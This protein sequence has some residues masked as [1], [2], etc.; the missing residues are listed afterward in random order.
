M[1]R[2]VLLLEVLTVMLFSCNKQET[3]VP[4]GTPTE[5]SYTVTLEGWQFSKG[6]QL[7]LLSGQHTAALTAKSS[8]ASVVFSG[9]A[10]K[11]SGEDS[12]LAIY[13]SAPEGY[14]LENNVFTFSLP[15]VAVP[16]NGHPC[17]AVATGRPK[18]NALQ[19]NHLTAFLSFTTTRTD[20]T[21]LVIRSNGKSL[22]GTIK[23]TLDKNAAPS[24]RTDITDGTDALVVNDVLTP[25]TYTLPIPAQGYDK[26]S[27][28][29]FTATGSGESS[30]RKS[31]NP[32]FG[33]T[34][35]LGVIDQ[36][37][38]IAERADA[39]AAELLEATSSTAAVTWSVSGFNDVFT[40]IAQKWSAGIYKD[41][42]CTDL[43]VSW[44]FPVGTWSVSDGNNIYALEGPYS[45]RFIF[46][47]LEG[48]STYYVKVWY[49]DN[50]DLASAP[51]KVVTL[52]QENKT[53]P[54]GFAGEGDVLLQEDFSELVWGGDVSTRSYGYSDANRGNAPA[55]HAAAGENPVGKQTI[56]GFEHDWYLAWPG[57]EMGL[58][59][60][61]GK[62]I[63]S[64]RLKDWTSMAEDNTDG[65]ALARPGYVKLGASSQT[66]ALV[67]PALTCLEHRAVVRLS[68]RMHPYR[69]AVN[70]PLTA[71]VMV[72]STEESGIS[73][74]KDYVVTKR[75]DFLVGE[76]QQWYSYSFDLMMQPGE[77]LAIASRREGTDANQRRLLVD[78]IKVELLEYR[79]YVKVTAIK[80]TQDWLDF[81]SG[82]TSYEAGET[83]T[84][85]NDLDMEGLSFDA[86]PSFVGTLDGKGHALL[87][88][89]S[90]GKPLFTALG[91]NEGEGGTVKD[92][93]LDASCSLT[94][95]L[96]G[97]FGFIAAT[98]LPSGVIDGVQIKADAVPLNVPTLAAPHIGMIAGVSYGLIQNCVNDGDLSVTSAAGTGNAY[99]GG[100][101]GYI[102]AGDR[103]GLLNNENN[104]DITYTMNGPGLFA[105]LGGISAGTSTT[106]IADAK[107]SKGTIQNCVN[108][109]KVSYTTT[110]GGSMAENEGTGR[111]GNYFKVGGVIGYFEGNVID[112]TNR[113]EVSARVPTNE[114]AACTTGASIGGVAAFVLRNMTGCKNYGKVNVSGTFAGGNVDNQGCGITAEF[115]AGGVVGQ[116]GAKESPEAYGLSDCHNYGELDLRGWMAYGNGTGFNFGGVVGY[117]G[118]PVSN[119]S[120]EADMLAESK[121]AFVRMGGVA[122]RIVGQKATALENKGALDFRFVRSTA[123]AVDTY[124]QLA[125]ELRAGGVAAYVGG[126]IEDCSNSGELKITTTAEDNLSAALQAGGVVGYTDKLTSLSGSNTGKIDITYNGK[127]LR[128]GGIVGETVKSTALSGLVNSGALN[129]NVPSAGQSW[130]GG[131]LGFMPAGSATLSGLENNGKVDVSIAEASSSAFYY[132]AGV[133]ASSG[134]GYKYSGCVN[135]ADITYSGKAKIRIGGVCAYTNQNDVDSSSS[136]N[137]KATCTGYDYSEV[138]GVCAYT[139]ATGLSGWQFTGTIDTSEST[140]K[141]YT[142]GLLGKSNGKAAFNGC[143]FSGTLTGAAGNNVPGL[144]V[145]G[146]QTKDLAMTFGATAKCVVA[147]GSKVNGAEIT[148]L[149]KENLVSQSS[150]GGTFTSTATLTNIVIE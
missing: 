8:G 85:E 12:Y 111:T 82:G 118:A 52:P 100:I 26:F 57:R 94:P 93:V 43:L 102:N 129:V 38:E 105:Y 41:E 76:A 146:L 48:A 97:N 15:A 92:L 80:T 112:C 21:S 132:V 74:L 78:D 69:E 64:T 11:L 24:G 23:V 143:S 142:G 22:A 37:I 101:V 81:V 66:G 68:F 83:V 59:N 119:C 86:I 29:V 19:L 116:I 103:V 65:K 123:G 67:T 47:G 130:I 145:G 90:E 135:K 108:T 73:V 3:E 95:S 114:G 70:D 89:T 120:N 17:G 13:P 54:E 6:D 115:A 128:A 88:W 63:P 147:A 137:I 117:A 113:G 121:G 45:P 125:S 10:P 87:N 18:D 44:D 53:I 124:K 62:A 4:V 77:R 58:F 122:G 20:I 16:Q 28:S 150:D 126:D 56:D 72:I 133:S 149:T 40:D 141:V 30:L 109:G 39:P 138:G 79:P 50:P 1:K 33:K 46:S 139:A 55:L 2:A 25:G 31:V 148:V 104:G 51:L 84:L 107:N 14:T 27:I 61:L 71:S 75:E 144:Y 35:D 134:T 140:A 9:K 91:Q 49:T 60:T 99:I 96:D 110:N 131:V 136:G 5:T 106:K 42:G 7:S 36:D 32:R 98:V 34:V 127:S